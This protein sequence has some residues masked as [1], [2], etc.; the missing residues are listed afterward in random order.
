MERDVAWRKARR[1]RHDFSA[2]VR[3]HVRARDGER[4]V[5]CGK[6]G[7]DV[8]HIIPRMEGGLGTPDNGVCLDP[9]CHHLAH[10]SKNTALALVRYR[11]RVLLPLY[12]LADPGPYVWLDP[13]PEERCPCGGEVADGQCANDCGLIVWSEE[14]EIG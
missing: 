2:A 10:R 3:A 11:Q 8:H 9:A 12:G 6:P 5:L 13:L 14:E 7:R 4:C 1:H